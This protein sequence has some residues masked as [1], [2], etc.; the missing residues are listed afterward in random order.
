FAVR[1]PFT[2]PPWQTVID[3]ACTSPST[4]PRIST[5]SAVVIDPFISALAEMTVGAA[6]S[7]IAFGSFAGASTGRTPDMPAT[8]FNMVIGCDTVR[9][10]VCMVSDI[11][12]FLEAVAAGAAKEAPHPARE[13]NFSRSGGQ[14]ISCQLGSSSQFLKQA[15]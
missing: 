15:R 9:R 5:L 11:A 12:R 14:G 4:E 7:G 2:R 10:A 6:R 1:S 13:L 8:A 3:A